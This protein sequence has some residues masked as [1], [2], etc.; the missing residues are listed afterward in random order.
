MNLKH[1]TGLSAAAA[2][3]AGTVAAA[4]A[5]AGTFTFDFT[6]PTPV[7]LAPSFTYSNG[8]LSVVAAAGSSG[9]VAQTARGLG[10]YQGGL[11]LLQIDR[12]GTNEVLNLSFNQAVRLVSAT[13][14]AVGRDDDFRLSI[15]S[16]VKLTGDIPGGTLFDTGSG[17]FDFVAALLPAARTGTVFSFDPIRNNDAYFI[18][19]LTV[20]TLP[21]AIPTPALLPGLIGV[22]AAALRRRQAEATSDAEA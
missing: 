11:D 4:P 8:P 15:D 7:E 14:G 3:A 16:L 20:E 2:L 21:T 10:I 5:Q 17:T 18:K 6:N 9:S 1:L 19:G 12:V 13:F 22:G